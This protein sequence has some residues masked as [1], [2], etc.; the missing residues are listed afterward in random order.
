MLTANV[1]GLNEIAFSERFLVDS[2]ADR[3]VFSGYLL[4]KLDLP[5]SPPPGGISLQGVSGE[6]P[7]V[8]VQSV[9][10]L[11]SDDHTPARFHGSFAAFTDPAA[12]DFSVL[13]RDVLNHFHVIVSQ[14]GSELLLLTGQHS[15]QVVSRP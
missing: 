7:F 8:V 2:G 6:V 12:T 3:T 4:Q 14:P 9:L 15:Y 10:E 1:V 13:G 11:V 5:T